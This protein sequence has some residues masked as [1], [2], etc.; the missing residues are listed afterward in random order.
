MMISTKVMD[1]ILF[2]VV[3]FFFLSP[4][5]V[6]AANKV[7]VIP[8]FGDCTVSVC[9]PLKNIV[10]VGK[11]NGQF[12]D[13]VAAVASITDASA[14][15]P[16]LVVIGPGVYTITQTLVMK[17]YVS[18]AGSG[19][20][21]TKITGAIS[22]PFFTS[23]VI[24]RGASNAALSSLTVENTGGNDYSIALHNSDASPRVSNVSTLANGGKYNIGVYNASSFPVMTDVTTTVA[25]GTGSVNHAVENTSSSP[26]MIRVS[27]TASGPGTNYGISNFVSGSTVPSFPTMTDVTALAT[28]GE[29]YGVYNEGSS[30]ALIRRSTLSGDTRGLYT[31]NGTATVS[32]STIKYGAQVGGGTGTHSCV[33]CDNGSGVLLSASCQ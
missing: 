24:V 18:I 21:T 13:P 5:T 11:S 19:E 2:S 22:T 29:S 25:G 15:N 28:G 4:L 12:T 23:S 8:L 3:V 27:A 30:S 1:R 33:A 32:Q 14:I 17:Q 31:V 6:F 7:V 9:N 20:E 16:Y 26:K 10:T